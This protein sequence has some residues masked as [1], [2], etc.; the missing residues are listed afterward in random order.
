MGLL[1]RGTLSRKGRLFGVVFA[2]ALAVTLVSGT[3]ALTDTIDAA[4][5]NATAHPAGSSDVVVRSTAL[6]TAQANSLPERAPVPESLVSRVATVP[7]VQAAWGAIQGYAGLVGRNGDAIAPTGLPS[8]GSGWEPGDV[9][10]AG[11]VPGPGEVAIDAATARRNG[12]VLG[13][14]IRVLFQGSSK[15]FTIGGFLKAAGDVV[16]ATKAIFDPTT[17]QQVLGEEGQVDTI[18]VTAVPGVSADVLRTRINAVLP[19][20]Y[21]A[22]TAAQAAHEAEQSWT[23]AVSFLPTALLLFA[24]VALLV[25]AFLIFNT[26]SILVAQRARE[27]GLLRALGASRAQ[28]TASVLIEAMAVGVAGSLAGVVLGFAAAHGLL[29]LLHGMGFQLPPA[30]VVFRPRTALVGML[31]GVVVTTLAAVPAARHAT[32]VTPVGAIAG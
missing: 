3:F 19:A 16:A 14:K 20:S 13:E 24:A 21:E 6:F 11:R 22:V 26:F 9:L 10:E 5:H 29:A 30:P 15:E 7:G 23:R 32:R 4:F 18:P 31:C 28:L 27:L 1:L 2:V 12:L 25:G 8:V 17:A